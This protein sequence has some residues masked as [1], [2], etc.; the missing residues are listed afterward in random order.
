MLTMNEKNIKD[1]RFEGKLLYQ[2]I[3]LK[4]TLENYLK[5]VATSSESID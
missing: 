3:K 5:F 2:K 1:E 4:N